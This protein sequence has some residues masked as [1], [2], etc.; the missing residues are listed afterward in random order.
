MEWFFIGGAFVIVI[1]ALTLV[2]QRKGASDQKAKTAEKDLTTLQKI[3]AK[4]KKNRIDRSN[5]SRAERLRD[6]DYRD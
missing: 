1:Y 2:S 6:I 3:Y 4:L 5:K